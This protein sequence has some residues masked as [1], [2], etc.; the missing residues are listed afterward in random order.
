MKTVCINVAHSV[1]DKG[2]Y[3][4]NNNISEYDLCTS[5]ADK[6]KYKLIINNII[7]NVVNCLKDGGSTGSVGKI[8]ALQKF[9]SDCIIELHL[10]SI[11]NS[12]ENTEIFYNKNVTDSLPLANLIQNNLYK[13]IF[14]NKIS[15][16]PLTDESS[17]LNQLEIPVILIKVFQIDDDNQLSYFLNNFNLLSNIFVKSITDFLQK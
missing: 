14:Y 10:N 9:Q 17:H 5:L 7:C 2:Y 1:K 8:R 15:L 13:N 11:K 16:K 3:S 12:Q 6:I 4:N